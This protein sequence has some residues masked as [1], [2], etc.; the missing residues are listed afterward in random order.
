[1]SAGSRAVVLLAATSLG[2]ASAALAQTNDVFY[3]SWRWM[4]EPSAARTAGLGGATT[5]LPDEA[6]AV[7]SNPAALSSLKKIHVVATVI[8]RGSARTAVGDSLEAATGMGFVGFG[9]RISSR[10]AVGAYAVE[11]Q[12]ARIELG[13]LRL[14][15][16][17][18]DAGHLEGTVRD[19]GVAAAWRVSSRL[20]L[21]ARITASHLELAGDYSRQSGPSPPLLRVTTEGGARRLAASFGALLEATP[22][23]TLGLVKIRGAR[24]QVGRSATSPALDA[25]LD[26]G[27]RY[28]V[29]EPS[30]VSGGLSW[31]PSPKAMVTGQVDY[32]RYGRFDSP[33]PGGYTQLH[34]D[35]VSWE[36]RGGF[37][38][39]LPMRSMSLQ[40]RGGLYG[41]TPESSLATAAVA[42]AA[43]GGGPSPAPAPVVS[44]DAMLQQIA[45]LRMPES[46][47]QSRRPLRGSLG[48]SVVL[49]GGLR[50]DLATVVGGERP[51]FL[52][53]VGLRF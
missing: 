22:R 36:W 12:A 25:T 17:T 11:P 50:V 31:R 5:A 27:S 4:N 49:A 10:W 26:P 19:A 48:A 42:V 40:L 14:P 8:R 41:P 29:S 35:L 47:I 1:M 7:E 9:G 15:D 2:G 43:A 13:H 53:G 30:V 45:A 34:Y 3:R 6:G 16:G 37:E 51:V 46:G 38:A 52:A 44:R 39:S 18:E 24:W 28:E 33:L 23:V 32:V 20:H 21:G